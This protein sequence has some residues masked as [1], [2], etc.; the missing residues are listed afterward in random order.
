MT[1]ARRARA[2]VGDAPDLDPPDLDQPELEHSPRRGGSRPRQAG[3]PKADPRTLWPARRR[4]AAGDH[5]PARASAR[6]WCVRPACLPA[7]SIVR[8]SASSLP[9]PRATTSDSTDLASSAG[10]GG[11]EFQLIGL[12]TAIAD[13]DDAMTQPR[14][15]RRGVASAGGV[16]H[17]PAPSEVGV[18]VAP[19]WISTVAIQPLPHDEGRYRPWQIG[20]VRGE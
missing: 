18:A 3:S 13:A 8:R 14:G 12:V 2:A 5:A 4:A 15:D 9:A 11:D 10:Q 6:T 16:L 7:S 19:R 1:G 20:D 17:T